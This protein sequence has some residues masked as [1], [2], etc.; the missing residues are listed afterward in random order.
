MFCYKFIHSR[1]STITSK[2]WSYFKIKILHTAWT[3]WAQLALPFFSF[4]FYLPIFV[5]STS[6]LENRNFFNKKRRHGLYAHAEIAFLSLR[7][8][9]WKKFGFFSNSFTVIFVA[10]IMSCVYVGTYSCAY[11][12]KIKQSEKPRVN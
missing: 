2:V 12:L 7:R 1:F 4:L 11:L 3:H 8:S 6:E 9:K 10:R 5:C